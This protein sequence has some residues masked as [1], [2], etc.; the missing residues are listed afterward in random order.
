VTGAARAFLEPVLA[1]DREATW[2]PATSTW[3]GRS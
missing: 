2:D 3:E 1:G